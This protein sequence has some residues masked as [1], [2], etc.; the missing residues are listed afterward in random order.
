MQAIAAVTLLAGIAMVLAANVA[1]RSSSAPPIGSRPWR[2]PWQGRET[3]KGGGYWLQMLGWVLWLAGA[4]GM[5]VKM[6]S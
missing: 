6:W 5:L 3:Y 1:M 4:L 2:L